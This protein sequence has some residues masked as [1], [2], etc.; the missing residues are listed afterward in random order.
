[1]KKIA[2]FNAGSSSLKFTLYDFATHKVLVEKNIQNIGTKGGVANHEEALGLLEVYFEEF[3][4]IGHRVV[5]GGERF[6][7]PTLVDDDV[8]E[9]IHHLS[10]LAPLHNPVNLKAIEYFHK[11]YPNIPQYCVFDTAFHA[12]M[13]QEAYRY[14]IAKDLYTQHHIRRYGFHGTS[15]SYLVQEAAKL[16]HKSPNKV[17]LITLHL[18]N[19]ASAC[20]IKNGKSI[21][22]SMG[23]TPLEGLV[24]GSRCGDIDAGVIFYLQRELSLGVDAVDAMLNKHAG[25]VGLCGDNDVQHILKRKDAD[26]HLAL[27]IMVRRVQKYIGAYMVLLE[28]DVDAIVLSGGI[29]EN[30]QEIQKRIMDNKMFAKIPFLVI[31]TDEAKEIMLQSREFLEG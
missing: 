14:A 24:M 8:I 11:H 25:L 18:G 21:D 12:T 17:R 5:H 31:Q 27:E 19:G 16:L 6:V 4:I 20:A 26:A 30:A 28:G 29:G 9:Q 7:A 3:C 2:V 10:T 15:H 1:M 22:T 23:F 13:P